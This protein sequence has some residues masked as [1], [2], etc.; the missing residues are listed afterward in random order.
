MELI[1]AH[2]RKDKLKM[3]KPSAVSLLLKVYVTAIL[4]ENELSHCYSP[5]KLSENKLSPVN[6]GSKCYLLEVGF[7]REGCFLHRGNHLGDGLKREC[8]VK[9]LGMNADFHLRIVWPWTSY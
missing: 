2:T 5:H 6:T 3:V 8:G 9:G 4:L 7:L 1:S